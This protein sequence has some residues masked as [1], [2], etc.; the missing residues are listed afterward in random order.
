MKFGLPLSIVMLLVTW[1]YLTRIAFAGRT[2]EAGIDSHLLDEQ[3]A[4]LGPV[5]R[6]E[7]YIMAVFLSVAALWILRGLPGL[8]TLAVVKDSTIAIGG[9]LLLLVIPVNL[10]C[11]QLVPA[12]LENGCY[13]PVG[14]H[15]AVRW[16]FCTCTGFQ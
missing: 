12:G 8:A 4:R 5:K 11:G 10:K 13:H 6:E 2:G 9:A 16:W 7:K 3:F 14:H 1:M 15:C